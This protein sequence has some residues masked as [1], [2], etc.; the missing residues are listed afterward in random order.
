MI[1]ELTKLDARQLDE[2]SALLVAVVDDG[3]SI[4]F[5]PPMA[6]DQARAYWQNVFEPGVRLLVA[7]QAG[8][9]VG[10]VQ[11]HLAMRANGSHRAEIARLM[12]HRAARRHGLGRALMNAIEDVAR[13]EQR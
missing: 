9:I 12:V 1:A 7:E 10:S 2:L 5:L 8:H 11:L 4:G 6:T 3:A 13:R